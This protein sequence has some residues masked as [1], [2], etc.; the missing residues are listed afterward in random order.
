[1][2]AACLR[3][4]AHSPAVLRGARHQPCRLRVELHATAARDPAARGLGRCRSPGRG[5][6]SLQRRVSDQAADAAGAVVG[7]DAARPPHRRA[8]SRRRRVRG[9]PARDA[10][11]LSGDHPRAGND[12]RGCAAGRDHHVEPHPRAA[13]CAETAL[14]VSLDRLSGLRQGTEHRHAPRCRARRRGWR[15]RSR[16]SSRNCATVELYKSAGVSETLDWVAALVALDRTELDVESIERTLGVLLKNQDDIRA[17][18]GDRAADLLA[19]VQV[20]PR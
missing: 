9:L 6:R 14:P 16:R 8:R 1:M 15:R 20:R 12:P 2:L 17:V 3:R 11:R 18:R 19:R 10:R 4:R 5:P 13:R 7:R